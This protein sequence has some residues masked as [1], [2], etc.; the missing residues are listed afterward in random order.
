MLR[1]EDWK[2]VVFRK[3]NEGELYDMKNDPG[4]VHNLFYDEKFATVKADMLTKLMER[5]LS[6]VEPSSKF[7]PGY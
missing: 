4:E 1:T 6:V 3:G 5:E 2:V 7:H